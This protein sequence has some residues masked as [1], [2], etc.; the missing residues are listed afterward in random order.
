MRKLV[1]TAGFF[2][3]ISL[4]SATAAERAWFGFHIKPETTGFP[5]NPVVRSVVIDK[6]KPHSAAAALDIRI[7]DQIMEVEGRTVPG[8]RA[9]QLISLLQKQP[10]EWLHLRLKRPSGESYS[11]AVEGIKKPD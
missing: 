7:G 8:T 6:V 3:G 9:L 5:L 10:G 2:L 11:A 1:I 4:A